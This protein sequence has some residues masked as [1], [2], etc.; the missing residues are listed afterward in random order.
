MIALTS[1][2]SSSESEENSES[3]VVFTAA[4]A[5][6]EENSESFVTLARV[7]QVENS[8][9]FV[10]LALP[11]YADVPVLKLALARRRLLRS[12]MSLSCSEASFSAAAA[13]E[14]E[15]FAS[16]PRLQHGVRKGRVDRKSHSLSR[17]GFWLG[18]RRRRRCGL[19]VLVR[20]DQDNFCS[21]RRR[22]RRPNQVMSIVSIP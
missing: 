19:I 17:Y 18:S 20:A 6:K 9:S 21:G 12:T 5:V 4:L 3:F 15:A 8:E 2:S 22:A 10:A 11:V 7:V 13:L 16:D 1:S 14:V